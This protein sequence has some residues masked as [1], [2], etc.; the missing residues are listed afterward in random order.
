MFA[1][2]REKLMLIGT[3]DKC[4]LYRILT[5]LELIGLPH[6]LVAAGWL[7]ERVTSK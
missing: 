5:V 3:Q 7:S 1:S 2:A 4:H 6:S